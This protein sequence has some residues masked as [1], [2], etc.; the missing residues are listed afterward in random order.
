MVDRKREWDESTTAELAELLPEHM[1]DSLK[2]MELMDEWQQLDTPKVRSIA[3]PLVV[4]WTSEESP[5][6]ITADFQVAYD[7][8]LERLA[9]RTDVTLDD[10]EEIAAAWDAQ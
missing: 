9:G 5:V 4:G 1:A 7:F 3:F 2:I 8:L 10:L 6:R